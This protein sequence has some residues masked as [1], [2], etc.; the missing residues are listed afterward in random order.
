MVIYTARMGRAAVWLALVGLL[1]PSGAAAID[2]F[3]DGTLGSDCDGYDI[4]NRSCSGGS[5]VAHRDFASAISAVEPGDRVLLRA[6]TYREQLRVDR[7]GTAASP[8][9]I[10]RYDGEEVRI[11]GLGEPA[12]FVT[13]A[14]YVVIEGLLVVDNLGFGR[15]ED[16]DHIVIRDVTFDGA[17]ANGTTGGLKLVRARQCLLQNNRFLDANDNVVMQESDRNRIIGNEFREGRHSLL[18]V[19]CSNENVF[20]ANRFVNPIQKAMEIFDCEGI[21]DAPFRLDATHRN[22]IE[23]NRFE[24]T[25]PSDRDHRYNA[26][27]FACQDSIVRR[28]VFVENAGGGLNFQIYSDEALNTYGNRAYHNTFVNNRCHAVIGSDSSSSSFRDNVVR[29]NVLWQNVDCDGAPA[30]INVRNPTAVIL[31]D[32]AIVDTDPGFVG[33]GDFGLSAAS[34]LIDT[35]AFLTETRADGSGTTLQVVDSTVFFDGRGIEG[36]LGDRI[37][38]DAQTERATI[39][40]IDFESHTLTL[41][42]PLTWTAGHGVSLAYEGS[43]PDPG[44]FERGLEPNNPGDGGVDAGQPDSG[45]FPDGSVTDATMNGDSESGGDGGCS[46]GPASSSGSGVVVLMLAALLRRRR[47]H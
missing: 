47:A 4:Q 40:S 37:Q 30:Q 7:S 24:G 2:R 16:S 26:I 27:Q 38:L 18:S 39:V 46:V 20:R 21:S 45:V 33:S 3:V 10:E 5:E 12:I 11:E 1:A 34:P 6:G 25:A 32:N 43:A 19:R 36:E 9:R 42:R 29:F 22:L 13:G 41:D 44:A 15:L 35:A 14:S 8:I 31:S 28:N 23:G 17:T